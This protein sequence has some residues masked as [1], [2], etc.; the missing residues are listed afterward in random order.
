MSGQRPNQLSFR[1]QVF[2]DHYFE[3]ETLAARI[4]VSRLAAVAARVATRID[5]VVGPDG[6]VDLLLI[7][8]VHI[9]ENQ[10]ERAVLVP[11]PSLEGRSYVLS[12]GILDSG[13][14]GAQP[15]RRCQQK[16]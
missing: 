7:V 9:P 10:R 8:P 3:H 15:Y 12:P 4:K 2:L 1:T 5:G 16:P 13:K 11:L 6:N 14:L